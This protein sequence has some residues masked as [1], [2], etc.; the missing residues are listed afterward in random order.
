MDRSAPGAP[1]GSILAGRNP[2]PAPHSAPDKGDGRQPGRRGDHPS[3]SGT[4]R[5]KIA[6]IHCPADDLRWRPMIFRNR[7]EA[8]HLLAE[9]LVRYRGR[10]P[11]V[12]A[13]P[14]GAVGM[15]AIISKELGGET[16]VI[17]VRKLR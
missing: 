15:A 6:V 16:D 17:L 4:A 1:T 3:S 5:S 2:A 13:I 8:A 7:E 14:R 11:L 12:L 9:R 10:N